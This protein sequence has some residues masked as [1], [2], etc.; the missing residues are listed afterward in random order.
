MDEGYNGLMIII[1]TVAG[2]AVGMFW[3]APPVFGKAWF[4]HAGL[5]EGEKP[6]IA[7]FGLWV[8]SYLVLAITMAYLYKHLGANN[9]YQGL[10]WG[11]TL[12]ITIVAMAVAGNYA[13]AKKPLKL[14]LI[15]LGHIVFSMAVM[16]A[17]IG[18][19]R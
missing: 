12:G 16:G 2:V 3:F 5:A 14:F 6:G 7:I 9:A 19:G 1:A 17:I 11:L 15:E 8:G 18:M 4:K 10:R 13:F